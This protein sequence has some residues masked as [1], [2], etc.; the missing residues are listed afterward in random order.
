[1]T[2]TSAAKA[3]ATWTGIAEPG[4][5]SAG[6]LR[7]QL[8]AEAALDWIARPYEPLPEEIKTPAGDKDP[9]AWKK[10]HQRWHQRLTELNIDAELAEL[11][12][13]G[14]HLVM[15]SDPDWPT[16][17]NDLG[18]AAPA[19]LWVMGEGTL[20][21][22]DEQAV[23]TVGST[24]ATTYGITVAETLARELTG[25]GIQVISGGAYGID[26]AAHR[27]RE[28]QPAIRRGR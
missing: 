12:T 4:D 10:H 3:A 7:E 14:G 13:L 19:A 17:L 22:A 20:P 5:T 23:S 11:E 28:T 21:S 1:M 9:S 24:A 2:E 8:G 6:A 16:Q 26:A 15:P 27:L 25:N 18:N